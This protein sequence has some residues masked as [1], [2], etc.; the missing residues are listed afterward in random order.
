MVTQC[1]ELAAWERAAKNARD[2][3]NEYKGTDLELV[4]RKYARDLEY[5]AAEIRTIQVQTPFGS[6]KWPTTNA[7][8][9][10]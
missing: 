6:A 10:P 4:L 9:Q 5:R 1:E 3:A 8:R 7:S 2:L